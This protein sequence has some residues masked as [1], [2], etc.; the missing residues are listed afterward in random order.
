MSM[1]AVTV[2]LIVAACALQAAWTL[3]P[4]GARARVAAALLKLPLP[5]AL[6][7]RLRKV[8]SGAAAGCG[9]CDSCGSVKPDAA[10]AVKPI[11][12]HRRAPR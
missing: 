11:T 8:A 6:A 5:A 7:M 4:A 10:N 3:S 2:A 1:Q 9:G 12:I